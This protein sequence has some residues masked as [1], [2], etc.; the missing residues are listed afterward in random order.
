MPST[1][2]EL[3]TTL[4]DEK[5]ALVRQSVAD[6]K[7]HRL[8]KD[9]KL[10]ISEMSH[11][12]EH[13]EQ[14]IRYL[15]EAHALN[16]YIRLV[17]EFAHRALREMR[18]DLMEIK[19]EILAWDLRTALHKLDPVV[20]KHEQ[21]LTHL[22]TQRFRN[23]HICCA[24]RVPSHRY[25]CEYRYVFPKCEFQNSLVIR[26]D[27]IWIEN[28]SS[29]THALMNLFAKLRGTI[30]YGVDQ[31]S[32]LWLGRRTFRGTFCVR[33]ASRERLWLRKR[34]CSSESASSDAEPSTCCA[35]YS[36]VWFPE[37][38]LYVQMNTRRMNTHSDLC[39][40]WC[41][42]QFS[43]AQVESVL[44][45]FSQ[46]CASTRTLDAELFLA[47][48][49]DWDLFT[50]FSVVW[51]VGHDEHRHHERIEIQRVRCTRGGYTLETTCDAIR[52]GFC[53]TIEQIRCALQNSRW[54]KI[55]ERIVH[56]YERVIDRVELMMRTNDNE[57]KQIENWREC[58]YNNI[59]MQKE[60]I[61]EYVGSNRALV[62]AKIMKVNGLLQSLE[63]LFQKGYD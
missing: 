14:Y 60:I 23:W 49:V 38:K 48:N 29:M 44:E 15:R 50:P 52:P 33:E 45:Y 41:D 4:R 42:T 26:N 35:E 10:Q 3:Y 9:D 16:T 5:R 36:A 11:E 2:R 6:S 39:L 21:L 25:R 37:F 53:G 59:C 12:I 51:R 7:F 40:N 46:F 19:H 30:V 43:D 20:L 63:T 31:R 54:T 24:H 13:Y 57:K 58:V 62:D 55:F 28:V 1:L 34:A 47:E 61:V 32:A 22:Q 56:F 27:N 17:Q 18:N 8:S